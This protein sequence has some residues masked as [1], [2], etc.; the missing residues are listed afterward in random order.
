MFRPG[1]GKTK[2]QGAVLQKQNRGAGFFI[3]NTQS[4]TVDLTPAP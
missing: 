4:G 2:F 3:G 1:A